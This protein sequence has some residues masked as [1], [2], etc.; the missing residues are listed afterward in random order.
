MTPQTRLAWVFALAAC[1]AAPQKHQVLVNNGAPLQTTADPKLVTMTAEP[2]TSLLLASTTSQMGV[3]ILMTASEESRANRPPLN[4]GLVLDTSGSMEG[5]AIKAVRDNAR[6]LVGKLR[7]GDHLSVV[8][9]H[10][11]ADVL[12]PN[13]RIDGHNRA[14]ILAAIEGIEAKGTTALSDGL[15]VGYQQ[16]MAG[17][18][19]NGINR[20]VLLSDGVPNDSTSLHNILAQIQQGGVSVTSLGLGID[21]D[22]QLMN[23]IARDTGGAFHYIKEPTELAAVFDDELTRMTRIVGRNLVVYLQP[24]PGVTIEPLPGLQAMG[25]GGYVATIGDLAAGEQRDLMIP[26]TATAR[27]EGS[28]AE[29][30]EVTMTFDDVIGHSGTAKRE[31]FV[32]VKA[33]ADEAAVKKAVK[34]SLEGARIRANGA[35]AILQALESTR[36]GQVEQARKILAEAVKSVKAA[37]KQYPDENFA[38]LIDQLESVIKEVAQIRAPQPQP[39]TIGN[40]MPNGGAK[41]P[42]A[43]PPAMAPAAVEPALR[44]AEETATATVQ[45]RN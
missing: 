4:L 13:V 44:A 30:V 38:K 24:G 39:L 3:R 6:E 11:H 37:A 17:T 1:G 29:L 5:D 21:Y 12:V 43:A 19:P 31:A 34:V 15:A 18:L 22:T 27:G 16:L 23:Q 42:M 40:A 45:G 20:L 2:T 7:E 25:N 9:F 10:S 35:A 41:R 8:A 14:K 33:S 32:G 36:A 28:T 26:I